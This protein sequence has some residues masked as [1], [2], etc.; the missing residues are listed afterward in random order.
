M[1]TPFQI[2]VDCHD[3][4]RM[5]QFWS[6]A[7][8]YVQEPPPAGYLSWEDFLRANGIPLPQPGSIGAIVDP[9]LVGPRILFIRVPEKKSV[10]NRVH[11][12]IRTSQ[13][14]DVKLAKVDELIQAGAQQ[15][16][17]IDDDDGWWMVMAD[18]EGNQFCVT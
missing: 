13:D 9:D 12:D 17:R 14:D 1:A 3:A 15:V 7:L 18:P 4:D 11:L 6:V 8:G 16:K 10:K 5:V 2:T